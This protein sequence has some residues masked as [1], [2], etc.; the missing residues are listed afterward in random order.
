MFRDTITSCRPQIIM[1]NYVINVTV[2]ILE[3][4]GLSVV[5]NFA[6]LYV[7][8]CKLFATKY[9]NKNSAH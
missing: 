2:V 1:N 4:Y 5:L 6:N 3:S 8:V 9:F 7:F